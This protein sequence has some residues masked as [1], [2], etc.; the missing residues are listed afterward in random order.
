M[1]RPLFLAF[2]L[3]LAILFASGCFG[4]SD[5]DGDPTL[6][7]TATTTEPPDTT[8]TPPTASATATVAPSPTTAPL[9]VAGLFD[10]PGERITPTDS[11]TLPERPAPT[12]PEAPSDHTIL[13]SLEDMRAANL[14]PGTI[15]QF[16]PNGEYMA[17]SSEGMV[18]V[19]HLATRVRSTLGPGTFVNGVSNHTVVSGDVAYDIENGDPS[20]KTYPVNLPHAQGDLALRLIEGTGESSGATYEYA[21]VRILPDGSDVPILTLRAYVARFGGEGELIVVTDIQSDA[22]NPSSWPFAPGTRNLFIV[23]IA[24]GQATFVATISVLGGVPFSAS[25]KYITWTEDYCSD[26]EVTVLLD[27]QTGEATRIV[28]GSWLEITPTNLLGDGWG[29]GPQALI[30]PAT[31]EYLAVLPGPNVDVRWS[32]DYRYASTG[33][34]G[35]HGGHCGG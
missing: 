19:V 18:H 25:E 7:P 20:G 6:S 29:F 4:D 21:V 24:T 12:F 30:D 15:G 9:E 5:S 33:E 14:G 3:V 1:V 23:D 27:R 28:G 35:G 31:M 17:W 26:D 22:E 32:A 8:A 13:Y 2:T 34:T 10:E 16:T 11:V